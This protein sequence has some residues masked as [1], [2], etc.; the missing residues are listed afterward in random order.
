[1]ISKKS[2]EVKMKISVRKKGRRNNNSG[3]LQFRKG[4]WYV[5]VSVHF[6]ND[7]GN[8]IYRRKYLGR[9]KNK[10]EAEQAVKQYQL[11]NG[12]SIESKTLMKDFLRDWISVRCRGKKQESTIF[13]QKD[14]IDNYIIPYIGNIMLGKLKSNDINLMTSQ[15]LADRKLARNTVITITDTLNAALN[16][17]VN[18]DYI[19]KNPMKKAAK[20]K[21][22]PRLKAIP[23]NYEQIFNLTKE[24][25]AEKIYKIPFLLC[26][27]G[28]LRRGEALGVKWEDIDFSR[29]T[30]RVSR[31]TITSG[32]RIYE[33]ELK[34]EKSQ[35]VIVLPD[36]VIE[37]LEKIAKPERKGFIIKIT[38]RKPYCFY[39]RFRK[40]IQKLKME[41]VTIHSLRH[42]NA[43]LLLNNGI[44]ID[45][46]SRRLGHSSIKVTGDIYAHEILGAQEKE[47]KILDEI[48]KKAIMNNN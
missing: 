30:L 2:S 33:K 1:M 29:K 44:S 3:N 23:N 21:P 42:I 27:Y 12:I 48:S 15:L 35:R 32:G 43:S 47:A 36:I 9:F 28:G 46:V 20:I 10:T 26:L 14:H 40:I 7:D 41:S 19:N 13:N 22:S 11:E 17:A 37:E 5:E 31:Q 38:R 18:E 34:T 16:Y 39:Y 45:S 8:K 24:I 25:I 6:I 4:F